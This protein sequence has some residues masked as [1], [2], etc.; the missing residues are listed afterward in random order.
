MQGVC[1]AVMFMGKIRSAKPWN[2]DDES[3][4]I[5]R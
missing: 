3:Q 2:D 1:I 5:I 4:N